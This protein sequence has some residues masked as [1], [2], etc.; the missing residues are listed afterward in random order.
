MKVPSWL[1]VL[2]LAIG[3]GLMFRSLFPRVERIPSPPRIVTVYDTV[4]R[5]DTIWRTRW[6]ESV[7][8][9]TLP[10]EVVTVASVPE[11]VYVAPP[12][13]GLLLLDVPETVGDST[14]GE[15]FAIMPSDSG[16]V[17]LDWRMQWWTSGPLRAMSLDTFPPRIAFWPAPKPM[18]SCGFLCSLGHYAVGAA[19][20]AA[21]WEIFR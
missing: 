2:V 5:L 15:G 3:S 6:R 18:R 8:W 10:A 4:P 9:D 20:G 21:A 13:Y 1:T 14:V 19:A 16:Y 17:R 12:L 7:R 11:T